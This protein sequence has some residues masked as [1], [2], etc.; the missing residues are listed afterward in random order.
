LWGFAA[1]ALEQISTL[2]DA[3]LAHGDAELHNLVVCPSPL[4]VVLVDFEAAVKKD[5]LAEA[6]WQARRE[7][8]LNPLLREAVFLQCVLGRQRGP[9]ADASWLALDRLFRSPERFRRAMEVQPDPPE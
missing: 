7:A 6:A 1:G 3:G 9:L 4:E 2:H 5:E 8:D